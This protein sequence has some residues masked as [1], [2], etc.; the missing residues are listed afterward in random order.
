MNLC[1]TA[2]GMTGCGEIESASASLVPPVHLE[3][4]KQTGRQ[5]R[6]KKTLN[7]SAVSQECSP[8]CGYTRFPVSDQ[9]ET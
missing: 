2:C 4:A 9:E 3:N 5:R 8:G 1:E 6:K 7:A